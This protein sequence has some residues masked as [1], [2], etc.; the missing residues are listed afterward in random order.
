MKPTTPTTT[1][2][3]ARLL[4]VFEVAGDILLLQLLFV[5][6]S[7]PVVTM[8]PAALALQRSLGATFV[9]GRPQPA[10]VYWESFRWAMVRS[11]KVAVLLPLFMIAAAASILFWVAADGAVGSIALMILIPLYGMAVAGY[12]AVLAAVME[13][14]ALETSAVETSALRRPVDHAMD[15]PG[16]WLRRAWSLAPDRAM[17]LALSV[18]VMATWL[19]LLAKL[20][21]LILV[22]TGL[23]PAGLA[24]WVAAPW[25]QTRRAQLSARS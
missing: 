19:L 20:P 22:G 2:R 23:V 14:S 15:G 9:E 11:W 8:L 7:L 6:A 4:S 10:K 13:T 18:I 25:V 5:V 12:V 21:T 17:P 24:W 3:S 1:T 16:G